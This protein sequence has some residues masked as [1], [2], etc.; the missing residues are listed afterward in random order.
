MNLLRNLDAFHLVTMRDGVKPMST[1]KPIIGYAV[2]WPPIAGL[3]YLAVT[4]LPDGKVEAKQFETWEAAE[5]YSRK[6]AKGLK[7]SAVKH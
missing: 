1:K 4:L 2:Y 6:M 5:E 7:P 3:P